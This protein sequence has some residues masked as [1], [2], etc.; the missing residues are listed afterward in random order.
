MTPSIASALSPAEMEAR[1]AALEAQLASLEICETCGGLPC[2][3]PNFCELCERADRKGA[4]RHHLERLQRLLAGDISLER[5]WHHLRP[6]G[7]A[8]STVEALM[9]SLRRGLDELS[10]PDTQRRLPELNKEQLE[11]VCLRVQTFEPNIAP[12][13]SADGV[14]LLISAWRKFHEQR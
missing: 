1:I 6:K 12:A 14:D 8:A 11:A 2:V 7:T 9:Y 13:W 4:A 5:V 10:R 3:N